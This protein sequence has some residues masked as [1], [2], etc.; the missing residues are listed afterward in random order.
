MAKV[1]KGSVPNRGKSAPTSGEE[2]SMPQKRNSTGT[3][4]KKEAEENRGGKGGML[5]IGRGTARNR[6]SVEKESGTHPIT[7]GTEALWERHSK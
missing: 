6:R 1:S 3:K 4:W 5:C 2:A 7:E